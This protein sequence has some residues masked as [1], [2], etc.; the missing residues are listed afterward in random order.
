MFEMHVRLIQ[1]FSLVN[2]LIIELAGLKLFIN[3]EPGFFLPPGGRDLA[4]GLTIKYMTGSLI[5]LY[6]APG[7]GGKTLHVY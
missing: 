1:R 7:L 6:F 4:P 3:R 5:F 2:L